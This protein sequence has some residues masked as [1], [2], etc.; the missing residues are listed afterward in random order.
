MSDYG[1]CRYN[2]AAMNNESSN[3]QQIW[4]GIVVSAVCLAAIFLFIK[5]SEIVNALASAQFGYLALGALGLVI[6]MIIRAVRWRFMLN[7]QASWSQVYHVQNIGYMLTQLLPLRLGDV[8]RAILIGNVPPITLAQGVSTMVVERILDLLFFIVLLPL[9]LSEVKTIPV[10]MQNYARG[11]GF[12]SLGLIVILIA[13]ANLRPFTRR[14]TST[15]FN[16]IPF[17]NTENWVR[18]V[19]ELLAGLSN[20]TRLKDGLILIFLSIVVWL[21]VI[22]A[23]R[24]VLTA[25]HLQTNWVMTAFIVCAAA[26]SVAAPSSPGQVGVFHAAVTFALVQVL[27][28]PE[29]ASASFAFLYHALNM[30]TMIALGIIGLFRT[31]ATFKQVVA[32]ARRFRQQSTA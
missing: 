9:T 16:W 14:I 32:S 7:N 28:Q 8:A 30:I 20:L 24:M 12:A 2:P 15:I 29:G 4:I 17:L 5:P 3:K 26:F 23:Y 11:L 6:F 31:G 25:V 19:D 21:P 27:R 13:A 18:R 1:L 10:W 22:F